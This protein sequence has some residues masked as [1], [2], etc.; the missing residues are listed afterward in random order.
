MLRAL[1]FILTTFVCILF[2]FFGELFSL[3]ERDVIL[4]DAEGFSVP[5]VARLILLACLILANLRFRGFFVRVASTAIGAIFG[6]HFAFSSA[7]PLTAVLYFGPISPV[8]IPICSS[9]YDDVLHIMDLSETDPTTISSFYSSINCQN[10][11]G[12]ILRYGYV[13]F[14]TGPI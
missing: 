1:G 8:E 5:F 7:R 9:P 10:K 3:V 4:G 13:W 12:A 2:L 11:R 14:K 6:L